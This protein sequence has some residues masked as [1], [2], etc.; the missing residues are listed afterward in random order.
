MDIGITLFVLALMIGP[1]IIAIYFNHRRKYLIAIISFLIGWTV[2]GAM[3]MFIIV[4]K[5]ALKGTKLEKWV[6]KNE[7][8]I[9]RI[10]IPLLVIGG[11]IGLTM[12]ILDYMKNY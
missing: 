8:I 4:I 5:D 2:I 3:V 11:A 6:E 10:G 1:G 9:T 7:K 12:S